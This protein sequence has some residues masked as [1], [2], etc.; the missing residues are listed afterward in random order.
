MKHS[1]SHAFARRQT[2]LV[3]A[4][5][6]AALLSACASA[7]SRPDPQ[8]GEGQVLVTLKGVPRQGVKG[9]KR[10]MVRDDY[11]TSVDSIEQG[12]NFERVRYDRLPDVVVLLESADGSPVHSPAPGVAAR[13]T[14][15]TLD[16]KGFD[17]VQCC[18]NNGAT[19]ALT[20]RNERPA[21]V[22]LF[23]DGEDGS[24]ASLRLESGKEGSIKLGRGMHEVTCDQDEK[25]ISHVYVT[26]EG[27]LWCGTS[28]EQAFFAG[29]KPGD[30]EI[31]VY[32]PRLP[33]VR[34]H[35]QVSGGQRAQVTAELTVNSLPKA[36]R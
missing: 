28:E 4:L 7:P 10:E 34:H 15:L 19:M 33:L 3:A 13:G 30:Y 36:G 6:V 5:I 27:E 29:L 24:F 18:V 23:F 11:V 25:A 14:V 16:K 20:V 2:T 8:P 21:A 35:V 32:A 26:F 1:R 22:D 31:T 12:K 9:P 17:H